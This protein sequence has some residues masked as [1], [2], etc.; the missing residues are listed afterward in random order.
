MELSKL[1]SGVICL[2]VQTTEIALAFA[3]KE[4]ALDKYH[5]SLVHQPFFFFICGI[6]GS[7]LFYNRTLSFLLLEK[8]DNNIA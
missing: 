6:M 3:F 7:N 2:D 5:P 8:V 4:I 1:S